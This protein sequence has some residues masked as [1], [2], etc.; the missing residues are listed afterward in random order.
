MT[1]DFADDSS[2][3]GR[4]L[5]DSGKIAN[6]F[7]DYSEIETA[8]YCQLHRAQRYGQWFVLKSL[9]P[10][11]ANDADYQA[12][13]A[14][15]FALMVQLS[16]PNII[17]VNG[18]ENDAHCGDS[19]VMEYVDGR[20]LK[21]FLEENPSDELKKKVV[22]QLLDAIGYFHGKQIVHQDLKPSN[23]LV[24][25]NGNN[26]RIIDFG[27]SDCDSFA[28]LKGPAYTKAYAAPEQLSGGEIDNRTDL[29]AFGLILRQLFP[30]RYVGITKECLQPQREKR[31]TSAEA[32]ALAIRRSDRER[33]WIPIALCALLLLSTLAVF[34]FYFFNN[35][36]NEKV[37]N[38]VKERVVM[39]NP[40][41]EDDFSAEKN[42]KTDIHTEVKNAIIGIQN[43]IA[44]ESAAQEM[45]ELYIYN[46]K[47]EFDSICEPL[48]TKLKEGKNLYREIFHNNLQITLLK[49]H[50]HIQQRRQMLPQ[51]KQVSFV[52]YAQDLWSRYADKY[53]YTDSNGNELYP[54]F[55]NL[56]RNGK[57]PEE[58]FARLREEDEKGVAGIHRLSAQLKKETAK[59]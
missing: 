1:S 34:S 35:Q 46:L 23:I 22:C 14:K 42:E 49:M 2:T 17:K 38:V 59:N 40:T 56:H 57:L 9:K 4:V 36:H 32:I 6:Q 8:G 37:E 21:Q 20:T 18:W 30:K 53:P 25:R 47:F 41:K 26:V 11:F 27:L 7:C 54:Y 15:E 24:T 55:E 50:I 39:L 28:V 45:L 48:D 43:D 12:M 52:Q 31:Y 5:N 16:H 29:Y 19:I 3:S 51:A 33:K 44:D 58:E 13:L 10:E